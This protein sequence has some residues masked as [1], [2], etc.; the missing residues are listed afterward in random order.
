MAR[1]VPNRRHAKVLESVQPG[2]RE[3]DVFPTAYKMNTRHALAELFDRDYEWAAASRTGLDRYLQPWPRLGKMAA[4][5]ERRFP[6]GMQTAL[7]ICARK[8][9]A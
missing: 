4:S 7:V 9:M 2:R 5:L 8:R 3:K 6:R 1:L